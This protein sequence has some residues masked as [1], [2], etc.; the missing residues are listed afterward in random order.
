MLEDVPGPGPF[1]KSLE[2]TTAL[3]D[4]AAML[5]QPWQPGGDALVET[6]E[7]IGWK[8]FEQADIHPGL[9]DG[10]V[11]PDV[12]AIEISH[13]EKVY[14]SLFIH[15]FPRE[16]GARYGEHSWVGQHQNPRF[17]IADGKLRTM[18]RYTCISV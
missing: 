18:N 4:S 17:P 7:R 3:T 12:G 1:P 15:V 14:V 16:A 5:D 11:G 9:D 6:W 13:S 2:K 10:T 8:L